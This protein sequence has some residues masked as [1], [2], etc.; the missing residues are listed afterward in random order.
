MNLSRKLPLAVG[1]ALITGL[2]PYQAFA[3]PNLI[4]EILPGSALF[5]P[6]MKGFSVSRAGLTDTIGSSASYAPFQKIGV[7]FETPSGSIDL[8]AGAGLMINDGL[9]G[10]I[11]TGDA[12]WRIKVGRTASLAP[13]IGVVGLMPRWIGLGHSDPRD[14][15]IENGVGVLPGVT[16]SVG[17]MIGFIASANYLIMSPLKVTTAQGW[18]ANRNTID[19]SGFLLQVSVVCRFF[20]SASQP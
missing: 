4:L 14:V 7:G 16:F 2:I 10:S 17:K 1:F 9:F 19:M 11:L 13:H 12:A 3:R 20:Q 8:T 5:S 18:S 15:S 6:R